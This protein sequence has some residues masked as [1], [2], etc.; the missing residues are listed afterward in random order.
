MST[1]DGNGR[2][3]IISLTIY[4]FFFRQLKSAA[5][6]III[7]PYPVFMLYS[8]IPPG[9]LSSLTALMSP[10][11][12][13]L[14]MGGIRTRTDG[15]SKEK[16]ILYWFPGSFNSGKATLAVQISQKKND[17]DSKLVLHMRDNYRPDYVRLNPDTCAVPTMEIDNQIITDSME[18]C[19]Y[20]LANYPGPGDIQVATNKKAT[21][22]IEWIHFCNEWDE[23][24]YSYGHIP[25]EQAI[26]MNDIRLHNLRMNFAQAL[27]DQ[28]SDVTFL[29]D[30][31]IK[32]IAGVTTM[33]DS[34]KEGSD[35]QIALD[36]NIR[37][38]HTILERANDILTQSKTEFLFGDDLSTG[39]VF[40]LPILRIF[41]VIPFG[42]Q[43]NDIDLWDQYPALKSYWQ[44]A[45]HNKDVQIGLLNC[46]RPF[47]IMWTMVSHGVPAMVLSYKFGC[48][49]PSRPP[50]LPEEIEER[51]K[52][53]CEDSWEKA[54]G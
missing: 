41:Q 49:S 22:L 21:E 54:R 2:A 53:A 4:G 13:L 7:Y 39:D 33:R 24:Q 46:V 25:T 32:K 12:K 43:L 16:P 36:E 51:I 42:I 6:D 40:F 29:V 50:Q 52:L 8:I 44:R 1:R 48:M 37:R 34:M 3:V 14:A 19:K 23:Y 47:N 38:L 10:P 31:Y 17:C 27:K 35:K 26:M 15:I 30:A 18:I 9:V 45:T 20:L 11:R 5:I 28:P